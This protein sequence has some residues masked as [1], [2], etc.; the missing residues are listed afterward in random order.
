MKSNYYALYLLGAAVFLSPALPAAEAT[1]VRDEYEDVVDARRDLYQERRELRNAQRDLQQERREHDYRGVHEALR[2]VWR[3]ERD[4]RKATSKLAKEQQEYWDKRRGT[5]SYR[6]FT[7]S[8]RHPRNYGRP[9]PRDCD[10]SYR[11]WRR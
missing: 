11:H 4:V 2:D 3:Q 8:G 9:A 6:G 5:D 1:S 10:D 7:S